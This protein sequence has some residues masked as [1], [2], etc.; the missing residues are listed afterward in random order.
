MKDF[1]CKQ[2]AVGARQSKALTGFFSRFSRRGKEQTEAAT[3]IAHRIE[4]ARFPTPG[5]TWSYL[6]TFT[7]VSGGK[8]E[9]YTMEKDYQQLTDGQEGILTWKGESF[10]CFEIKED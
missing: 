6:V 1:D 10:L 8:V 5:S 2:C 3:V 9:L 7:L 4:A